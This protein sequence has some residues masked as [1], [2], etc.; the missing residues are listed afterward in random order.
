MLFTVFYFHF[1]R[2]P[3]IVLEECN[4]ES[5]VYITRKGDRSR[6]RPLTLLEA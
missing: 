4:A 3:T 1:V 2:K 6:G 5:G